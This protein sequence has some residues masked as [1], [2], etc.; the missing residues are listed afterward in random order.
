MNPFAYVGVL[1][2]SDP[3]Q[4][5]PAVA[6]LD[7]DTV[8]PSVMDTGRA[9]A[10]LQP[11]AGALQAIR[12]GGSAVVLPPLAA[13]ALTCLAVG[14]QDALA[15]ANAL[16]SGAPTANCTDVT[17]DGIRYTNGVDTVNVGDGVAGTT[18]VDPGT[19]GIELSLSGV[20]GEAVSDVEFEIIQW[21]TDGDDTTDEV[22]VVSEDGVNPLKVEGEFVLVETYDDSGDPETFSIGTDTYSGMELV[23]YLAA[24]SP[25]AG[26]QIVGG[27][28]V[29]N[30]AGGAGA[31]MIT[32]DA[33]GIVAS[34][35][36]GNGGSGSCG[37]ILFWSWCNDAS[38]G[39]D[40]G[41]VAV[42]G[43][44]AI[45]VAGD[46]QQRHGVTAISQGGDGG[47]GGGWFG[48]FVS[49]PGAG[50]DGGDGRA[51][52]VTL[53]ENSAITTHGDRSHGVFAQSRGGD[54]G[55]GGE[56]DAAIALG[57]NGGNGG[58]AGSVVVR[59]GGS[60]LTTGLNAHG[61]LARSV[62]AGAGAGSSAD[63]IYAEGG[64]GGG[65]SS[66]AAVTVNN[67][68]SVTTERDDSFGILA[69]SIGGGGGDG[70]GAGGW[71]T[72]GGRAGSG[73]GAGVVTIYDSGA[74]STDGDRSTALFAQSVGGGGGNGGDAVSIS[75]AVG[76]A[77]GGAGG[78][79]GAGEQVFVTADGSDIDTAGD[80]AHGIHAQ[81]IGGGG[82]NGGLAVAGKVPDGSG[83]NVS[84]ALGGNGGGG[85]SAGELVDVRTLAGTT[86]DTIGAGS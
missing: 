60:I 33:G 63:G 84:V 29:N 17:V 58:D 16:C 77:V 28:T 82:G 19:I 55:A 78:L 10:S 81:S 6:E 35:T 37:T 45:T 39:G 57:S 64:N 72:V 52:F 25:D 53:G 8:L 61:I 4:T 67:G 24:H 56:A 43:N 36:G 83:L 86:I 13:L 9:G 70:G 27:L 59:N 7:L 54:G 41:S 49:T 38:D 47:N 44:S 65:E 46:A 75:S 18:T 26:G 11:L 74:V 51:V 40:A 85:G 30:D 3:R 5:L 22:D 73:G 50:G 2:M 21:D 62:G 23:E 14:T 34:S 12:N 42:N 15:E 48:L 79:G 31:P 68:G 32:T 1:I 71:F 76:V 20:S 80:N 69:Q 66:G